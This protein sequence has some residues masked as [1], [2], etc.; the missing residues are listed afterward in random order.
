MSETGNNETGSIDQSMSSSDQIIEKPIN[1]RSLDKLV[2]KIV[3]LKDDLNN[4][5]KETH[6]LYRA[7]EKEDDALT[8]QEVV[9]DKQ[10]ELKIHISH[11]AAMETMVNNIITNGTGQG[12]QKGSR[13][14]R[15]GE[16]E[17]LIVSGARSYRKETG[18]CPGVSRR[19]DGEAFGPF[20]DYIMILAKNNGIPVTTQQIADAIKR[21]KRTPDCPN[22]L[23]A[24]EVKSP[25]QLYETHREKI[26]IGRKTAQL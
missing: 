5:S 15:L 23:F 20:I 2:N 12:R 4:L 6:L 11:L 22:D 21:L 10:L 18:L 7:F 19:A 25:Q 24:K 16:L 8:Q 26:I 9:E 13:S 14:F 1:K 3:E 17:A